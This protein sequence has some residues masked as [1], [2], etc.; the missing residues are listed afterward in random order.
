MPRSI[1]LLAA[2]A[3]CFFVSSAIAGDT[4]TAAGGG[5][6]HDSVNPIKV[7]LLGDRTGHHR[8]EVMAKAITP[9][10]EKLGIEITFTQ[11]INDLNR[12]TLAKY[13]CLAIY[14]DSGDLPAEMKR[15]CSATSKGAKG[16]SR[17][18]APRISFETAN[19][20]TA[21]VGGR[22]WKHRDRRVS[23]R[24]SSTPSIP[25]CVASKALK[26]GTRLTC[27]TS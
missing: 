3:S 8:P 24:G 12:A 11:N 13:D 15:R 19:K 10:L 27:T 20:Y 9:P 16:W 25:R 1:L 4:P 6:A 17:S 18:I 26:A 7:L 21:L 5:A 22:F 2:S 23:Q 14:G